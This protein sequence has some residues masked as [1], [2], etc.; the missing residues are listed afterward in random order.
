MGYCDQCIANE[1]SQRIHEFFMDDMKRG[2]NSQTSQRARTLS[3][4]KE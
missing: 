1:N 2:T 4:S 3:P